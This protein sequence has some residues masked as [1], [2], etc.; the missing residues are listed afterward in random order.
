MS[1]NGPPCR[2][3]FRSKKAAEIYTVSESPTD[4]KISPI[5]IANGLSTIHSFSND[6]TKLLLF[7][8]S[9]GVK[10]VDL[11]K[12]SSTCSSSEEESSFVLENSKG[13]QMMAFSSLGTYILTWERP[14]KASEGDAPPNLKI[15]SSVNG[16][17]LH[18]FQM[19]GCRRAQW[20][21]VRWSHDEKYAFH[22]S[23]NQLNV[24]NGHSF[25]E[26]G[27]SKTRYIDTVRCNGM[28]SFNLPLNS[29]TA[30]ASLGKYLISTFVGETKGKPARVSLLRYPDRCG[31]AENPKSG[32]LL[33]SKS[34]YQAEE[35]T[36]KW[37]PQ[38]DSVLIV[39]TTSVD[40]SG[41]S[42][43]GSTNL[44]LLLNDSKTAGSDGEA[45]SVPLPGSGGPVHDVSWMPN[46]NKP[47]AF[48]VV[49]GRMPAM[50]SLH[51][52]TSAEAIFLFGNAHRNTIVWSDHGR[53]VTL[54][55]FGNLAGGMDF[56]DRNKMKPIPQYDPNT[57]VDMGSRGNTASCAVG[58]GWSPNSR[59]FMVS[60]TSPR[61]NVDNGVA[62]YKYNGLE[63][64]DKGIISWNNENFL[65][66]L[67]LAVEFVPAKQNVYPDRPQSPPPKRPVGGKDGDVV[68]SV[69]PVAPVTAYVPPVGRYV[70]PGVRK[71]G[72][73]MSLADRMRKE[74]E[75]SS[76]GVTKVAPKGIVGASSTKKGPVGMT[77]DDGGKSKSALRKERLRLAKKKAEEEEKAEA[78]RKAIEEKERISAVAADPVKRAKKLKKII[79]QI[80]DLKTR[81]A[82]SLNEDQLKKLAMEEEV[83]KELESLSV[84]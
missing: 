54:G 60:T 70:P 67:L 68:E 5:T 12:I 2:I 16:R 23:T 39:T 3:L 82:S 47:S 53:F 29:N 49:S 33:V 64:K 31:T 44:Y 36:Y 81:D 61:M 76:V 20:P 27:D 75:G 57:G 42:Y 1:S 17:Y 14:V 10:V 6:G 77:S 66:N 84:S 30:E 22:Q 28:T 58:Y 9:T 11:T 8:P 35:C 65:P 21:P 59:F 55:G 18:G 72:G 52:G 15:W 19:K 62:L 78:E 32:N 69:K 43:Y 79:K 83:R 63:I 48:A 41:E 71:S 74:R 24:Y 51:H 7:M 26:D 80:D 56:Y 38:G 50:T 25:S 45:L 37:S 40:T 4:E 46:P 34:F 73:S 13:V